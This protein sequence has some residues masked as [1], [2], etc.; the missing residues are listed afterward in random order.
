VEGR[1]IIM[2]DHAVEKLR[3]DHNELQITFHT[4]DGEKKSKKKRSTKVALGIMKSHHAMIRR[5][6][7]MA[8]W[9]IFGINA[10]ER[11]GK[12]KVGCM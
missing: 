6:S 5:R 4:M 8:C 12:R 3:D 2:V 7:S 10:N 1:Q 11:K 9:N